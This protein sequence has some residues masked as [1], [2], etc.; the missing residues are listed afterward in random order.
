MGVGAYDHY[1]DTLF[2][3]GSRGYTAAD[4]IKPDFVAPGVDVYGP[5]RA[6][7]FVRKSGTS[8]AAA[9]CAGCAALILQWARDRDLARFVNGNQIRNYFIR[10]AVRPGTAGSPFSYVMN[11]TEGY[12]F[13][14]E[15]P[16]PEWGY[17]I[18]NVY[19]TFD[20]LRT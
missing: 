14:R 5:G 17:G 18:L 1:S 19:N 16:N 20:S 2:L 10:G 3:D 7:T 11:D 8:V 15:Y 6:G 4:D 13:A 9:H 12:L